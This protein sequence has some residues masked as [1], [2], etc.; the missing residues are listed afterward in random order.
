MTRT[1]TH[2]D[3]YV[4]V[5]PLLQSMSSLDAADPRFTRLRDRA[6][7][8]CPP[9]AEHVARRF[10]GRGEV[11]E[12]IRRSSDALSHELGRPPTRREIA[13]ELRA[14]ESTVAAGVLAGHGY[15]ALSLDGSVGD[16]AGARRSSHPVDKL[17]VSGRS[18]AICAAEYAALVLDSVPEDSAP[19]LPAHGCHRVSCA[20]ET[21][22]H[23]TPVPHDHRERL[24]IVV[25][26]CIAGCHHAPPGRGPS[27]A[28]CRRF[29]P[30]RCRHTPNDR[31]PHMSRRPHDNR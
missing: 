21:V 1:V 8:R 4:D 23:S 9:S 25:A 3:E 29:A 27:A 20:L 5:V 10:D 2:T 15:R 28:P 17:F 31:G 18:C 19:A 12:Q 16:A 26:A 11:H 6:V 7:T 22:E 13:D 24:V 14:E 30:P